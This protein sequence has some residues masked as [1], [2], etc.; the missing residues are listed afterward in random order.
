[1][2]STISFIEARVRALLELLSVSKGCDFPYKA[3][4]LALSAIQKKHESFLAD[5]ILIDKS[6]SED[7]IKRICSSFNELVSSHLPLI[8]FI[9]RSTETR[10]PF[11]V[12]GPLSRL[13][14]E[15]SGE[16][17]H[18]VISSEW[19]ISPHIYERPLDGFVFIG[20]PASEGSNPLLLPSAG[21]EF[22]HLVWSRD[23]ALS[24]YFA[25]EAR[26]S[27]AGLKKRKASAI[28]NLMDHHDIKDENELFAS[29]V[30]LRAIH[31]ALQQI[32]ECFCDFMGVYLFKESYL[33]AFAYLSSP[34]EWF[35]S[36]KYP[37]FEE[38]V[39]YIARACKAYGYSTPA[40]WDLWFSGKANIG[41]KN[42]GEILILALADEIRHDLIDFAIEKARAIVVQK[43]IAL[44]SVSG[45][46]EI[47]GNI[48]S[49][50]VP[51][52]TP[53]TIFDIID[54]A[55]KAQL[56][57]EFMAD[58][59]SRKIQI[60]RD[61]TLKNFEVLDFNWRISR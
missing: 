22:G 27:L 46:D 41:L 38:R 17:A 5:L 29:N 12:Y 6:V 37:G 14:E 45:T 49:Y 23:Q 43:N 55:W 47:Y 18:L 34:G 15:L 3:S 52:D 24:S 9:L 11:E 39:L 10:N 58:V 26:K 13:A 19:T 60:I 16:K 4:G 31:L 42:R 25:N 32:Q 54:A 20:L 44:A 1:M 8:G 28:Q 56:D 57:I 7:A 21:H 53:K 51:H 40:E 2:N 61:L 36:P 33:R 48:I 59:P 50:G 35:R 30:F